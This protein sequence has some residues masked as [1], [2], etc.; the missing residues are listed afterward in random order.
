MRPWTLV[1]E[2]ASSALAG[3]GSSGWAGCCCG[4]G[5]MVIAGGGVMVG[6]PTVGDAGA[7]SGAG[8][9]GGVGVTGELGAEWGV[10]SE[11]V[12]RLLVALAAGAALELAG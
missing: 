3:P 6:M 10:G 12:I 5:V 9:G 4:G 7:D 1:G 8:T 11:K 2:A